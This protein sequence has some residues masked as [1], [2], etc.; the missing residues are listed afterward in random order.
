MHQRYTEVCPLIGTY[1]PTAAAY[2]EANGVV[3]AHC[4]PCVQKPFL[5]Q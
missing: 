4:L 5:P 2:A 1:E 3:Q